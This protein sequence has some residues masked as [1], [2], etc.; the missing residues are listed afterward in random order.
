MIDLEYFLKLNLKSSSTDRIKKKIHN[1]KESDWSIHHELELL[2]LDIEDLKED[3]KI[4][5]LIKDIGHRIVVYR[6]PPNY[7]Y[8]WHIDAKRM[9][10]INMLIEGFDSMCVFGDQELITIKNTVQAKYTDISKLQHE[11]DTYYLMNV[12]KHHTVYNFGNQH[13]YILSLGIP[14]KSFGEVREYLKRNDML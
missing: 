7:C 10:S 3:I 14:D 11:P 9:S 6:S 13:R 12:K 2:L 1:A 4:T 5:Q 8:S